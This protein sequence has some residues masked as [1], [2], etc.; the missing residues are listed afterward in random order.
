[1]AEKKV[2][3]QKTLIYDNPSE[4]DEDDQELIGKETGVGAS[5]S[6]YKFYNYTGTTIKFCISDSRLNDN[7][8]I[9]FGGNRS[10]MTIGKKY[11]DSKFDKVIIMK[12]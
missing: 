2:G 12:G 3:N 11:Q 1:M 10:L 5:K 6:G 7:L 9:P 4:F 8:E